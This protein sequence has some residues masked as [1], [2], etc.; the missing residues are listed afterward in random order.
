MT[1]LQP[2]QCLPEGRGPRH[3]HR[4]AQQ[5]VNAEPSRRR[6]SEAGCVGGT[7]VSPIPVTEPW[8]FSFWLPP[9][10]APPHQ[11]EGPRRSRGKNAAPGEDPRLLPPSL[12]LPAVDVGDR[13]PAW[14]GWAG[15]HCE[16]VPRA[17]RLCPALLS[18]RR[19]KTFAQTQP[20]P[21]ATLK[22]WLPTA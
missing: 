2:Q 1:Q 19:K 16:D 6:H 13:D 11:R 21:L 4:D 8:A 10:R 12:S 17:R 9:G 7:S 15:A 3:S 20:G 5:D 22:A 18:D 14:P